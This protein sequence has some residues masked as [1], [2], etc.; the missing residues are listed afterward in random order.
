MA[1]HLGVV[2]RLGPIV[3][4][5]RWRSEELRDLRRRLAEHHR[6]QE[7]PRWLLVSATGDLAVTG[8]SAL[9]SGAGG[10][11]LARRVVA[12]N[13]HSIS[14]LSPRL[15]ATVTGHVVDHRVLDTAT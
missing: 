2:H 14:L 9:R 4:G 10:R 11:R 13:G 6:Q 3:D 15:V 8:W 7:G 1:R 12:A 5:L